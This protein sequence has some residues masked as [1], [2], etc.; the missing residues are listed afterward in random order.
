MCKAWD[1]DHVSR[2]ALR[3]TSSCGDKTSSCSIFRTCPCAFH[4]PA[5]QQHFTNAAT[6]LPDLCSARQCDALLWVV[7]G[8]AHQTQRMLATRSPCLHI[9]CALLV[10]MIRFTVSYSCFAA[11]HAAPAAQWPPKVPTGTLAMSLLRQLDDVSGEACEE[12]AV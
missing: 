6:W 7:P 8:S 4:P 11:W 1:L 2:N 5:R 3:A 12:H 10:F 9:H